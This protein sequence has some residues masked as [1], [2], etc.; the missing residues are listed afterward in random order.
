MPPPPA[1]FIANTYCAL[2]ALAIRRMNLYDFS[3]Y[4]NAISIHCYSS[5]IVLLLFPF[6]RV[7][8]ARIIKYIIHLWS[9]SRAHI[10][11]LSADAAAAAVLRVRSDKEYHPLAS[12]PTAPCLPS[13]AVAPAASELARI[14]SR[15][16]ILI[17]V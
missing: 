9:I 3:R 7:C 1:A 8:I 5:R 6:P 13:S 11:M 12:T 2:Y 4:V 16:Y 15:G 17:Y 14:S 10:F